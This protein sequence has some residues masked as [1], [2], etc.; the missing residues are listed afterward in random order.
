MCVDPSPALKE[1]GTGPDWGECVGRCAAHGPHEEAHW[2]LRVGG[3]ACGPEGGHSPPWQNLLVS[4][5]AAQ[6]P[7]MTGAHSP[8]SPIRPRDPAVARG[9]SLAP[10]SSCIPAWMQMRLT[11]SLFQAIY[12]TALFPYL[13]LTIFLIRGLTLPGAMEGLTYLFTPD[14]SGPHTQAPHRGQAQAQATNK[15]GP[16]P[17][18]ATLSH[19]SRE[20]ATGRGGPASQ[21]PRLEGRGQRRVRSGRRGPCETGVQG[22]GLLGTSMP[23]QGPRPRISEGLVQEHEPA[24][25]GATGPFHGVWNPRGRTAQ[26]PHLPGQAPWWARGQVCGSCSGNTRPCVQ[27][28]PPGPQPAG[29]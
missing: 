12:F 9:L 21:G 7:S 16:Q 17:G 3:G 6:A 23:C 4:V 8:P 13:V 22:R 24:K 14:V 19:G 29:S 15:L 18:P 2:G 10:P 20:M 1:L 28:A 25:R 26:P 11:T 27:G 5:R